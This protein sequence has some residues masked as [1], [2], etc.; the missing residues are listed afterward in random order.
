MHLGMDLFQFWGKGID[1]AKGTNSQQKQ[2]QK[3][4]AP[5]AEWQ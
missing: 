5:S 2:H 3:E 1:A 4:A